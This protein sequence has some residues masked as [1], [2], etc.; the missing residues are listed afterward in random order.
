MIVLLV[1]KNLINFF[2]EKKVSFK[3]VRVFALDEYVG[4]NNNDERS[5]YYYMKK[6]FIKH[7][8]ID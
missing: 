7:I 5:Y 3:H 2:N 6:N 4:L 1:Y 8:D